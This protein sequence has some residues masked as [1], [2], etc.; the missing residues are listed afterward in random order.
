VAT[1]FKSSLEQAGFTTTFETVEM[2][3][4]IVL[5]MIASKYP[6]GAHGG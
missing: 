1:R 4:S 6:L 5:V 3:S 2:S